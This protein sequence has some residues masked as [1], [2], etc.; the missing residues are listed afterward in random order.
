DVLA[1][2]ETDKALVELAAE[3]AGTLLRRLAA[4]GERVEVG[5][6]IAVLGDAG[7]QVDLD[8]LLG[9]AAALA[10]ERQSSADDGAAVGAAADT[11]GVAEEARASVPAGVEGAVASGADGGRL[12]ASPIARKMAR[13]SGV[14]LA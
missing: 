10:S 13:E 4:D 12:F 5:A 1:E 11:A 8:A 6:P 14:D 2:V 7:E 9:S 3:S